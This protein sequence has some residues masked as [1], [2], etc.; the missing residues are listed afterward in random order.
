[1]KLIYNELTGNNQTFGTRLNGAVIQKGD[2]VHLG[3]SVFTFRGEPCVINHFATPHKS[4]S[5]GK[6]SVQVEGS[7][8][9]SEFYVSVIGAQWIDREDRK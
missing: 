3:D 1:M 9:S 2:A 6:I 4:S 5:E 8:H 7:T